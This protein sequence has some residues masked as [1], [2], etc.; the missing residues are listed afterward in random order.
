MS[1]TKVFRMQRFDCVYIQSGS[2]SNAIVGKDYLATLETRLAVV[3]KEIASFKHNNHETPQSVSMPALLQN[4]P[5]KQIRVD[6]AGGGSHD[7]VQD[8]IFVLEDTGK[9]PASTDPSDG[10][11]A[12][13]F[14][15]EKDSGFFGPSSNIAFM[16]HISRAVARI[17]H[18][19]QS[20]ASPG[21][22]EEL[23][24]GLMNVSRPPSPVHRGT[25]GRPGLG[26]LDGRPYSRIPEKEEMDLIKQ[27]FSDTRLLFPYLHE[28]T[29]LDTYAEMKR[30]NFTKVRRTSPGLLNM[31]MALATSTT[32]VS[33]MSA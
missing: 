7:R 12:V 4:S 3:E 21:T 26:G 33:G 22:Q 27:Y 32:I 9:E 11:G 15:D 25:G 31:V 20:W 6:D 23:E 14:V 17:S 30:T 8:S 5:Q 18:I 19:D 29:L 28:Q 24:G 10:M 2:S 13:V 16:R 1:A